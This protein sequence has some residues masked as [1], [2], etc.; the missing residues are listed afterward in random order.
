MIS[1]HIHVFII[2]AL[3]AVATESKLLHTQLTQ[4]Q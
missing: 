2:V 3:L 4:D 1:V